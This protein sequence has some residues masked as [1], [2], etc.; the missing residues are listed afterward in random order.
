ME[1]HKVT[2]YA[3]CGVSTPEGKRRPASFEPYCVIEG[4]PTSPAS[5]PYKV[6]ERGS[7]RRLFFREYDG[8][9]TFFEHD[10]QDESGF[11]GATFHGITENGNSFSVKGPWSSS[12]ETVNSLRLPSSPCAHIAVSEPGNPHSWVARFVTLPIL[13]R[14]E[15]FCGADW[16]LRIPETQEVVSK[17]SEPPWAVGLSD[18]QLMAVEDGIPRSTIP[19]F[20]PRRQFDDCPSCGGF[21]SVDGGACSRCNGSGRSPRND[22]LSC[23]ECNGRGRKRDPCLTCGRRFCSSGIAPYPLLAL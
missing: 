8:V 7:G 2:F 14:I 20:V 5:Y 10:P 16:E 18:A 3:S 6:V 15:E 9:V 22:D 1:I 23:I 12:C 4:F 17:K 11:G 21:S 13:R 19:R